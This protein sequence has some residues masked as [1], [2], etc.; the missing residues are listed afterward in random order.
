MS[1]NETRSKLAV[2]L[3][4]EVVGYE[5][6]LKDDAAATERAV[7]KWQAIFARRAKS[8]AGEF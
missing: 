1:G 5:R 4:V 6:L 7:E 2:I 3:N 8:R